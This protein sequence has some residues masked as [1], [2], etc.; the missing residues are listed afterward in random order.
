[1]GIYDHYVMTEVYRKQLMWTVGLTFSVKRH[2][3]HFVLIVQFVTFYCASSS[4]RVLSS[5]HL[6][7]QTQQIKEDSNGSWTTVPRAISCPVTTATIRANAKIVKRRYFTHVGQKRSNLTTFC[8]C[9]RC[10]KFWSVP[11]VIYNSG[12]Q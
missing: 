9:I 4:S 6:L 11:S 7:Q 5:I 1:M 10:V 2:K 12:C 3:K 8:Y